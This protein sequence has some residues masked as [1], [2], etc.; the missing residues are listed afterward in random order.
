MGMRMYG[1]ARVTHAEK[2]SESFAT[3]LFTEFMFPII[4]TTEELASS[5]LWFCVKIILFS[6]LIFSEI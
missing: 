2:E 4:C 3:E 5:I 1:Y 6:E